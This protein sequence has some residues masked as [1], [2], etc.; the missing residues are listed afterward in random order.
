MDDLIFK[1]K[2]NRSIIEEELGFESG[3]LLNEELIRI[4]VKIPENI[5][6]PDG[7][8]LGVNNL[9]VPGG[10]LP[11]GY[12]EAVINNVTQNKYVETKIRIK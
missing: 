4:D 10:R 12:L 1:A 9:W 6:I 11:N 3:Y 7:N 2:G 5:R 8:E